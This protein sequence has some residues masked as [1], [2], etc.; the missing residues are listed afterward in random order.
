[1]IDGGWHIASPAGQVVR[2]C[3]ANMGRHHRA[4]RRKFRR[5]SRKSKLRSRR[6]VERNL[7]VTHSIDLIRAISYVR[8]CML[9][10]RT[11]AITGKKREDQ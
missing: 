7:F 5:Q 3:V 4:T 8:T 9:N 6:H 11:C 10:L 1:M 2:L